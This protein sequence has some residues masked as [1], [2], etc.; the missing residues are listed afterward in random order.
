MENCLR[1]ILKD[2]EADLGSTQPPIRAR[3]MVS[4]GKLARGFA[5]SLSSEQKAPSLILDLNKA[6]TFA[7]GDGVKVD[8]FWIFEILRL[9]MVALG[10]AE[11][12]VYLAAVQTIVAVGDLYPRQ[13]LPLIA[14]A[15]ARGELSSLSA[16]KT[17]NNAASIRLSR[18]QIIKLT[19]ALIFIIRRRAVTD[20]YVAMIANLM[21]HG[22]AGTVD[23]FTVIPEKDKVLIQK[24]TEKYFNSGL[25]YK[26]G[27]QDKEIEN[28]E[29]NTLSSQKDFWEERD[30]RLK[31]GGPVFELEETDVVRS[32]RISV[33]SELLPESSSAVLAPFLEALVRLVVEAFHLDS[34]SRAM[35][36]SAVLLA[37]EIY[38]KVLSEGYDLAEVLANAGIADRSSFAA[39]SFSVAL[40]AN[41]AEE[42]LCATLKKGSSD[43]R[44]RVTDP[45]LMT[46]CREA[47]DLREQA[48]EK[49]IFTAA[50]LVLEERRKLGELPGIFRGMIS[51][52]GDGDGDGEPRIDTDGGKNVFQLNPIETLE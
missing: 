46:R 35:T 38:A 18:E 4:L 29:N 49:G 15:I 10:D 3:G 37:R 45:T 1:R 47:L 6:G 24:E 12:Y 48:E 19:E 42:L 31:T 33:L 23:V 32:L 25:E 50:G 7:K 41:G 44:S 26:E 16:T 36:R 9:S 13:V 28:G 51:V 2:A 52:P 43:G 34:E 5:G 21:L 20:E 22:T 27:N 30:I 11:S 39:I 8:A 14:S 17:N 40:V